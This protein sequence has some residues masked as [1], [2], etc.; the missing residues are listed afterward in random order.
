MRIGT[1]L[2]VPGVG[3]TDQA[4]LNAYKQGHDLAANWTKGSGASLTTD[5]AGYSV[6]ATFITLAGAGS[7]SILNDD[8]ITFAGDP[9]FYRVKTGANPAPSQVI[10]LFGSGLLTNLS[11]AT[12][13][14]TIFNRHSTQ[15]GGAS[16]IS[17]D[18]LG[19][20][21]QMQGI[22]AAAG[23][24]FTSYDVA[25]LFSL[26]NTVGEFA[27]YRGGRWVLAWDG[28]AYS[29]TAAN[30][31]FTS[32]GAET[33]T[34]IGGTDNAIGGRIV[35]NSNSSA[36]INAG[37]IRIFWK[38][39]VAG[40]GNYP[41]NI[42]FIFAGTVNP[43]DVES[44]N[45]TGL[46]G[47][48]QPST[49]VGEN[50]VG[51]Y[52]AQY[53]SG[54][55]LHPDFKAR[56]QPICHPL[57]M[58][59]WMDTTHNGVQNW[60]SMPV[61]E[62]MFWQSGAT[63]MVPFEVQCAAGNEL[64]CDT[65]FNIP[66][67][68]S[69][70][71][72]AQAADIAHNGRTDST[73]HF[74]EPLHAPNLALLEAANEFWHPS[75]YPNFA[76]PCRALGYPLFPSLTAPS[77]N[78]GV[79]ST[80]LTMRAIQN[81]KIW[82]RVFGADS[83]RVKILFMGQAASQTYNETYLSMV[84]TTQG[85]YTASFTGSISAGVLTVD[86]ASVTGTVSPSQELTIGGVEQSIYITEQLTGTPGADGTYQLDDTSLSA[87]ASTPMT[88]RYFTNKTRDHIDY[89]GVDNYYQNE[90][91]RMP[92]DVTL[93]EF[94]TDVNTGGLGLN[95]F[96]PKI[97][98]SIDNGSG[99]GSP[100]GA[101]MTVTRFDTQLGTAAGCLFPGQRILSGAVSGT[102][103]VSQDS[104]SRGDGRWGMEGVYTVS[105]SQAYAPASG[106]LQ[107]EGGG[108]AGA[109][110][111]GWCSKGT[112]QNP[113]YGN[114][115]AFCTYEGGQNYQA[116]R[117]SNFGTASGAQTNSAGYNIGDTVITLNGV[118]TGNIYP[119][120]S[121]LSSVD[122]ITFAGDTNKYR[123][124]NGTSNVA[125]GGA[126]ITLR[127]PGLLQAIPAT[128]T[129]ITMMPNAL[130]TLASTYFAAM[131]DHRFY[132]SYFEFF[133]FYANM[134]NAQITIPLAITSE[135]LTG[136]TWGHLENIQQT[137]SPRYDAL[138]AL[139]NEDAA[140]TQLQILMPQACL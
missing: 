59:S 71:F 78:D 44:S 117:H 1:G 58:M 137:S 56:I 102:T 131:R 97:T 39:L 63:E 118:G 64:N 120:A 40:A 53:N 50:G 30:F 95:V 121:G 113:S 138:I 106:D 88:A 51:T 119:N 79:V 100:A 41:T 122:V 6:G 32:L 34:R 48:N 99:T 103:I 91:Q 15:T 66:G 13:A 90:D 45:G 11:A 112:A 3:N 80:Y 60:S 9:N 92:A 108:M 129:A 96:Y 26:G 74:W 109:C 14:I 4:F 57:R 42:R 85:G 84:S 101:K 36:A 5:A 20:P 8:V 133:P 28:P 61:P 47:S 75:T 10:E 111:L 132:D 65:W 140:S 68:A 33:W 24:T 82:R 76:I 115:V 125:A 19:H 139:S 2:F 105:I 89:F 72:V 86:A 107:M 22:G 124:A 94:F 123:I 38:N 25:T 81:G 52:E 27:A 127:A 128:P 54:I 136:G 104:S 69:Y 83:A 7:G 77:G 73:G 21:N 18:A 31:T 23:K 67:A 98:A 62:S 35:L 37:G 93:D 43:G 135:F 134:T 49:T 12:H 126:T 114:G 29:S 110:A 116:N 70:D 87:G 55:V 17:R 130:N 46:N 16:L